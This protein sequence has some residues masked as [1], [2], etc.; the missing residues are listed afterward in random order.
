MKQVKVISLVSAIFIA[1]LICV[2]CTK[3]SGAN[4]KTTSTENTNVLHCTRKA[5]AS[6]NV[7]TSLKYS[8]YYDRDYVTK[9][10]SVEKVTSSDENI[11]TSYKESYEKVFEPYK[12]I[13][14]Y[15]N[16]VSQTNDSVISTT[17]INYEKVDVSKI[18]AIEGEDDNIFENDGR[19]KKDTLISLFKKY[20]ATCK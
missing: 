12:N 14:Y 10:V 5:T 7:E 1:T 3:E 9:T 6:D 4:Q 16:T 13:D 2:G 11:L 18:I 19:V 17:V 8:I 20:G 15:E